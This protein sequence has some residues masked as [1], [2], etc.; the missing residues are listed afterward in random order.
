M[1]KINYEVVTKKGERF[2]TDNYK[3]AKEGGNRIAKIFFTEVDPRSEKE[4][5]KMREWNWKLFEKRKLK[6][7]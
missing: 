1:R 6:R 3:K 4:I 5:E 2:S 7:V